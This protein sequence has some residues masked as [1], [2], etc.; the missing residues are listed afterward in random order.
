M[1]GLTDAQAKQFLKKTTTVRLN[2][3]GSAQYVDE[4]SMNL[5]LRIVGD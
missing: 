5:G 1:F 3:S 4:A 2:I